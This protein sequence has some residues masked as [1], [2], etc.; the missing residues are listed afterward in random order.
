MNYLNQ[1]WETIH[2][3]PVTEREWLIERFVEQKKKEEE[4]YKK[5]AAKMRTP[6]LRIPHR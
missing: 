5:Q 3:I 2:S 1:S 6:R 4:E